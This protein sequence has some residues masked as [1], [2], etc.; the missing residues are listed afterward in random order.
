M[1]PVRVP[2]LGLH[3]KKMPSFNW[4]G[5]SLY[6]KTYQIRLKRVYLADKDDDFFQVNQNGREM[7]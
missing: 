2:I 7:Y 4:H 6:D 5:K 3:C 1:L